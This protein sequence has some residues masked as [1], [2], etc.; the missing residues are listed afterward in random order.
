MTKDTVRANVE[1][2][3]DEL[4]QQWKRDHPEDYQRMFEFLLA[5]PEK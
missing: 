5:E 3:V 4:Y 1:R 2:L